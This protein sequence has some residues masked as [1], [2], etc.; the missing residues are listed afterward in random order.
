[1][2]APC[3]I[4]FRS[5]LRLADNPAVTAARERGGPVV[6]VFIYAPEEESP[7]EPGGASRW[8]LHQSLQALIADL[9]K[10]GSRLIVRVGPLLANLRSL[11]N[12]TGARAVFWNR[13]YEPR[14]ITRD[15]EIQN[16]LQA[17]GVEVQSFNG[18]LLNEPWTVRN[19]SGKPFQVFTAFWRHCL[20]K[21][22]PGKPL[23]APRKIACPI[24]WPPSV[25]LQAL[26]LEPRIKWA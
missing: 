21:P 19:H 8:W 4:W 9:H 15:R 11:I 17:H 18:A 25:S 16:S 5:D 6:P 3:L 20:K 26:E 7:W 14:V 12:E 24:R 22:G 13:R 1:M 2:S 23:P 10:T